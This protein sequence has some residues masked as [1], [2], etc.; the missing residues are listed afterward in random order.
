M[1]TLQNDMGDQGDHQSDF[2]EEFTSQPI[3]GLGIEAGAYQA[4]SPRWRSKTFQT[5]LGVFLVLLVSIGL[6]GGTDRVRASILQQS[7]RP[8]CRFH[9]DYFP[10]GR[11]TVRNA[12]LHAT[13]YL[14]D[15]ASH[16]FE[17]DISSPLQPLKHL[18]ILASNP[19]S[20]LCKTLLTASTLRYP[21]PHFLA[22]NQTFYRTG[23][24]DGGADIAKFKKAVD[25]LEH[26]GGAQDDELVLLVD[27]DDVWF[28]LPMEI[29][30]S[31][32][33]DI[34]KNA[35][36]RFL[37]HYGPKATGL[38]HTHD[39]EHALSSRIV[40]GAEKKCTPN[41]PHT[42]ACYAVPESPLGDDLYAGNTDSLIGWTEH[43]S[44]RPRYLNSGFV[45]GP[46]GE[47]RRMFRR[48]HDMAKGWQ[49]L[50]KAIHVPATDV[51][52]NGSGESDYFYHGSDQSIFAKIFGRQEYVREILRRRFDSSAG[53]DK[54]PHKSS[55]LE[56]TIIEDILEPSWHHEAW[57]DDKFWANNEGKLSLAEHLGL[58]LEDHMDPWKEDLGKLL[59]AYDFGITLDYFSD[60][61]H[62]TLD[63]ERDAA[64]LVHG[65][66]PLQAQTDVGSR[67]PFDCPLRLEP[68]QKRSSSARDMTRN[69]PLDLFYSEH[70]QYVKQSRD[71]DALSDNP[72]LLIPLYTQLCNS[73][74]AFTRIPVMIHHNGDK[75]RRETTWSEMSWLYNISRPM[76]ESDH[77]RDYD[78][79]Q[80]SSDA[81]DREGWVG[82]H[83]DQDRGAPSAGGAWTET[84]FPMSWS[85][86]CPRSMLLEGKVFG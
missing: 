24:V 44:F 11:T 10:Q 83:V 57:N 68:S 76:L 37:K 52:D 66:R 53:R 20:N 12:H 5:W 59:D 34:V 82:G 13:S 16:A 21:Q 63:S 69:F 70:P 41:Q 65:K 51:S 50:W 64:W 27:G 86:V 58:E 78:S 36:S 8:T 71:S 38:L 75:S 35:D 77:E 7:L 43:S 47:M 61:G 72:W 30:V 48:A 54:D 73:N 40:F 3:A 19:S 9:A 31:R 25:Y 55:M 84:G 79:I 1:D 85:Q 17:D 33:H 32:Y 4:K 2:D 56:G 62:Q 74:P 45:I 46:A 80:S 60:L 28:Q 26:L 14:K 18:L 6:F 29:L 42:M 67:G 23:M 39:L 49:K 81:G 22:W 15:K